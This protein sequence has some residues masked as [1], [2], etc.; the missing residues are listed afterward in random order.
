MIHI[1]V[2]SFASGE[3]EEDLSDLETCNSINAATQLSL[4]LNLIN[5]TELSVSLG[6]S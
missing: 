6:P 4:Q 3:A 2:F 5:L 1:L